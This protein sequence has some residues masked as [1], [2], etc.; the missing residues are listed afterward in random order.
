M[1]KKPDFTGFFGFF[2]A[3]SGRNSALNGRNSAKLGEILRLSP[4]Q[5]G[6]ILLLQV[7]F[8]SLTGRN[9]ALTGRNSAIYWEKFCKPF[10]LAL[11]LSLPDS[12]F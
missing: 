9:S 3:F 8:C 1:R 10:L 2:C 6:G 5:L 11:L 7:L 12:E 4:F